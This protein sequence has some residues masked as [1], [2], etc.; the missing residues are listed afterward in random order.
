MN[1]YTK[2]AN[3]DIEAAEEVTGDAMQSDQAMILSNL[4]IARAIVGLTILFES[5][6]DHMNGGAV[7]VIDKG[8]K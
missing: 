1:D 7:K 3:Q 2:A 6:V 4:A 5:L 8:R